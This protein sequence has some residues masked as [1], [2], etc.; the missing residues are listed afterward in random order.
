MLYKNKR[1]ENLCQKK[2]IAD[3]D[4][5]ATMEDYSEDAVETAQY[6]SS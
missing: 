1:R 2:E 5:D 4:V 6:Y 3:A